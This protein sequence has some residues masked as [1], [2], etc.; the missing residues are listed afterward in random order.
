M[1]AIPKQLLALVFLFPLLCW[2]DDTNSLST[3]NSIEERRAAFRKMEEGLHF[4]TGTIT[5]KDGLATVQ[6]DNGFR[7]L[8]TDDARIV[9]E[10]MWGNPPNPKILGMIV[11]PDSQL[12]GS[13]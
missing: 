9:L 2:G 10:K 7:F 11:P 8:G 6:A 4:Q 12:A 1:K 3:T 5:L 13:N